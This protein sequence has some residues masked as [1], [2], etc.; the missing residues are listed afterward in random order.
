[1][2]CSQ[3]FY[4]HNWL[5]L[6]GN[7]RLNAIYRF[8]RQSPAP[9]GFI[10]IMGRKQKMFGY[11]KSWILVLSPNQNQ[12]FYWGAGGW[13]VRCS[14]KSRLSIKPVLQLE[15]IRKVIAWVL[16][17]RITIN[18][19]Q[20]FFFYAFV[21]IEKASSNYSLHYWGCALMFRIC[22]QVIDCHNGDE[23]TFTFKGKHFVFTKQ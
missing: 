15:Y 11:S 5:I 17:L 13:N 8:I 6:F 4:T 2:A 9:K 19:S 10:Y 21:L 1:M 20:R 18:N 16:E 7:S 12:D 3:C 22:F 23:S 14:S